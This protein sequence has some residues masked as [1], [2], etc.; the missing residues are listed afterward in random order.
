MDCAPTAQLMVGGFGP[1]SKRLKTFNGAVDVIVAQA[2]CAALLRWLS[3]EPIT[4]VWFAPTVTVS[5]LLSPI[6][7][8]GTEVDRPL[9]SKNVMLTV[10][11]ALPVLARAMRVVNPPPYGKVGH[12]V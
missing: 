10:A 9:W 2:I 11:V 12:C 4:W 5:V 3:S 6:P 8:N 7:S 1:K